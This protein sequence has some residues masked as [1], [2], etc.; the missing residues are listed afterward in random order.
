[1]VVQHD[2]LRFRAGMAWFRRFNHQPRMLISEREAGLFRG[3]TLHV[4]NVAR[5]F[6]RWQM[7]PP[8]PGKKILERYPGQFG[9]HTAVGHTHF[10]L[11]ETVQSER[12]KAV[13]LP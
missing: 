11:G 1:M 12:H 2:Q 3:G 10:A 7:V 4:D 5:Y 9:W 13:A 8:G 6:R